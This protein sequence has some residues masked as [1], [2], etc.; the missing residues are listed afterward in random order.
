M[1]VASIESDSS[2]VRSQLTECF[3]RYE[4]RVDRIV[5]VLGDSCSFGFLI[6]VDFSDFNQKDANLKVLINILG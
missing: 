2:V 5:G 1:T 6:Y 4:Q 3:P